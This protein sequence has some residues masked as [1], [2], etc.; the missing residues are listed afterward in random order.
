M[1]PSLT[2]GGGAATPPSVV[3]GSC[4]CA[5]P[6]YGWHVIH[7]TL[8]LNPGST[9]NVRHPA[10]AGRTSI[11]DA[12]AR[13]VGLAVTGQLLQHDDALDVALTYGVGH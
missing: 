1:Y 6:D 4:R 2:Q 10:A 11:L 8:G 7:T 9:T 12:L 13:L 3:A 5:W